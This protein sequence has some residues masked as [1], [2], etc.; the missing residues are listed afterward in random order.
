[1]GYDSVVYLTDLEHE[2]WLQDQ[3][4]DKFADPSVMVGRTVERRARGDTGIP[5]P[6]SKLQGLY[7]IP[8]GGVTVVGGYPV[9]TSQRWQTRCVCTRR[10]VGSA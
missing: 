3:Y 5:T 8:S 6:W 10:P 4:L 2:R 1:M 9:Q 7:S